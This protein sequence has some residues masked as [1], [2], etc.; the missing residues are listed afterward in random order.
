MSS[1]RPDS[2][3][4][5]QPVLSGLHILDAQLYPGLFEPLYQFGS[6]VPGSG[7]RYFLRLS[8]LRSSDTLTPPAWERPVVLVTILFDRDGD[9]PAKA[10]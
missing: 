9:V 10:R 5:H 8:S 6:L 3:K 2:A 7:T 4:E 1:T